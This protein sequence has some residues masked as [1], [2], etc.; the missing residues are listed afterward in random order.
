M[1]LC[2][3]RH[4]A[5]R[6][7]YPVERVEARLRAVY[8]GQCGWATLGSLNLYAGT[9]SAQAWQDYIRSAESTCQQHSTCQQQ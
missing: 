8:W 7:P 5:R 4:L 3:L 1:V 6:D 2:L 9:G